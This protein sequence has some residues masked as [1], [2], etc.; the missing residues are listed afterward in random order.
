MIA[1]FYFLLV[2]VGAT[3]PA[4]IYCKTVYGTSLANV[5]W[6]HGSAESLLTVTN[7]LLGT[8]R[9]LSLLHDIVNEGVFLLHV[10]QSAET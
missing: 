3:I 2:F 5:D 6:I 9:T 1:G 4:G 7:L 10:S 8:R